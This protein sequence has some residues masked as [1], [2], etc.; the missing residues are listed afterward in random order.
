MAHDFL[1]QTNTV[2][3]KQ[4]RRRGRKF[5]LRTKWMKKPSLLVRKLTCSLKQIQAIEKWMA[6]GT[7]KGLQNFSLY[8][9]FLNPQRKTCTFIKFKQ[10][11]IF[12]AQCDT[13]EER[14]CTVCHLFICSRHSWHSQPNKLKHQRKKLLPDQ[15]F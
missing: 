7:L 12:F 3:K 5:K 4:R 11:K 15:S 14:G 6:R 8:F 9:Y 2:S 13:A 10:I 1:E